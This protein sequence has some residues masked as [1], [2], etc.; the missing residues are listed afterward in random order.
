M[1]SGLRAPRE[2]SRPG[3]AQTDVCLSSTPGVKMPE[4]RERSRKPEKTL[5]SWADWPFSRQVPCPD[6]RD[7]R[8]VPVLLAFSVATW[9]ARPAAAADAPAAAAPPAAAPPPPAPA[10]P[11]PALEAVAPSPV[12]DELELAPVPA[13]SP[14]AEEAPSGADDPGPDELSVAGVRFEPEARLISGF[15]YERSRPEGAQTRAGEKEY[16]FELKQARLGLSAEKGSFRLHLSFDLADALSP[17]LGT[18]YDSPAYLRTATLEYRPLRALR[19]SVGRFKRPFS[20]IELES[21]IDLPVLDRGLWNELAVED[22]QWGDRAVGVMASG[23]IK[24]QKLRW[25]VSL[26]NPSWSSSLDS[27][28]VDVL[29][30]VRLSLVKGLNLGLNGGYK[31]L[32]FAGQTQATHN[33]GVGADLSLSLGQ[34]HV[35]LEGSLVDLPFETDRPRGFG[36]L[37]LLD[38]VFALSSDWALQP[39]LFAELADANAKV[40]GTESVRLAL[41]VNLLASEHFRLMPQ[42]ALVRALGDPSQANPWLESETYSLIFSLAL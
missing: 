24:F 36:T 11:P 33:Y 18:S 42:L 13:P 1:K 23:R 21:A 17:E 35:L 22:N 16:G 26:T 5:Q 6:V 41:G 27:Q 38:Y 7:R 20:A 34:A 19:L 8:L 25:Q 37:L 9:L 12:A 10:L 29:G 31:Y 4:R 30:R 3:R 28:G 39:M 40:S 14:A 32:V 2:S 15:E